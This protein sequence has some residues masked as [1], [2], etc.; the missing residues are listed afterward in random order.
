MKIND[1]M[2]CCERR[3]FSVFGSHRTINTINGKRFIIHTLY[4]SLMEL[5]EKNIK[6][7]EWK[8]AKEN[9]VNTMHANVKKCS[10]ENIKK[11]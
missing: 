6:Q 11:G 1:R 4:K 5:K 2:S 3:I 7:R 8:K 9:N 10:D